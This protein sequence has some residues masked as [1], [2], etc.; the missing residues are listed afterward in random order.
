[1]WARIRALET[2]TREEDVQKWDEMEVTFSFGNQPFPPSISPAYHVPVEQGFI[3]GMRMTV[4]STQ[5]NTDTTLV[6]VLNDEDVA[7]LV[8][9]PVTSDD[10]HHELDDSLNIDVGEWD[11]LQVRCDT[12]D[13][14][15][16]GI[17][18]QVMLKVSVDGL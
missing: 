12:V 5:G 4:A 6:L 9:N 17:T 11:R 18:L 13:P 14:D 16:F 1:M 15:A 7:T 3:T 10:P 2:P 8:F